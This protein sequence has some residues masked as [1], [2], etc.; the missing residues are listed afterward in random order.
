[1]QY[2]NLKTA[3]CANLRKYGHSG[4]GRELTVVARATIYKCLGDVGERKRP[5]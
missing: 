2:I 3:E 4:V 1:M 5:N